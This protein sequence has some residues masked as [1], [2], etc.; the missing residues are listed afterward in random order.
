MLSIAQAV[1]DSGYYR[2]SKNYYDADALGEPFWFGKGAEALGPNWAVDGSTFDRMAKG[3][4]PDGT[5]SRRRNR[6][7]TR[8]SSGLGP[9]LFRTKIRQHH[10]PGRWRSPID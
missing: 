6:Q 3:E 4:L 10:G 7:Q 1:A 8:A 9:H 2:D 5:M